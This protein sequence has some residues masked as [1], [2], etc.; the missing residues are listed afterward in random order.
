MT[1]ITFV[2]VP[3]QADPTAAPSY[4]SD[5][6]SLIDWRKHTD[7][8]SAGDVVAVFV[9]VEF[10][11]HNQPVLRTANSSC[12]TDLFEVADLSASDKQVLVQHVGTTMPVIVKVI[13]Y[14]GRH[15]CHGGRYAIASKLVLAPLPI[16]PTGQQLRDLKPRTQVIIEGA[17]AGFFNR[18]DPRNYTPDAIRIG[19]NVDTPNG[20][21]TVLTHFSQDQEVDFADGVLENLK[22]KVPL[23]GET[24]RYTAF[25]T[26]EGTLHG[27]YNHPYLLVPDPQRLKAYS[28]LRLTVKILLRRLE[29]YVVREQ[30]ARARALFAELRS[31]EL[32]KDE[33]R[34]A[35]AL[36]ASLPAG[37]QPIYGWKSDARSLERAYGVNVERLNK[38]QFLRLAYDAVLGIRKNPKDKK[39]H[40]DV[41]YFF[42]FTDDAPFTPEEN[43]QLLSTTIWARLEMLKN[44]D[45]F[46]HRYLLE[47]AISCLG[48]CDHPT[49]LAE[50]MKLVERCYQ[51]GYFP[52][53]RDEQSSRNGDRTAPPCP[54]RLDSVMRKAFEALGWM[55]YYELDVAKSI[56]NDK[57][58]TYRDLLV[59][60]NAS[61]HLIREVRKTINPATA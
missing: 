16:N 10:D 38:E 36:V 59:G 1:D 23:T 29:S 51:E 60:Q 47:Q 9:T 42:R 17:F 61:P 41:S 44:E 11:A 58:G 43:S 26:E 37:E 18:P 25:V 24:I 45:S 5:R 30:F 22:G 46:G 34:R 15:S 28:R 57:L 27:A 3:P 6:G 8:L 50:L 19:F 33:H 14:L 35:C 12:S 56:D 40:T 7:S 54:S 20:R 55:R 52:A 32:T 39:R 21:V 48:H 53:A 4:F 13:S 49:A 2:T 31:C